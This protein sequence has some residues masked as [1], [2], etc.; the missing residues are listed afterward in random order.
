MKCER[1]KDTGKT[2]DAAGN[3]EF[4]T[5]REGK[6]Q[7]TLARAERSAQRKKE[8]AERKKA[9][10]QERKRQKQMELWQQQEKEKQE[11]EQSDEMRPVIDFKP[12]D[13]V[14][15]IGDEFNGIVGTLCIVLEIDEDDAT[16]HVEAV[17]HKRGHKM[18]GRKW[19]NLCEVEN[20]PMEQNEADI[21]AM[22]DLALDLKDFD[23][24]K[25]LT[26][27]LP[28]KGKKQTC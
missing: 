7:K 21:R 11:R 12:F 26:K 19:V 18:R 27:K 10:E 8:A 5:C 2:K 3:D 20:I 28:G 14:E 4:C 23:W 1:C 22:I 13:W 17:K 9:A 15:I 16:V 6:M 24:C 25:E